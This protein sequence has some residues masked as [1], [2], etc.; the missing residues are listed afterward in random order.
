M[1]RRSPARGKPRWTCPGFLGGQEVETHT[2]VWRDGLKVSRLII[3]RGQINLCIEWKG[4]H[5]LLRLGA[6][7]RAWEN[8]R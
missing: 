4:R 1:I 7:T 8:A 3:Y 6:R 2:A 5:N